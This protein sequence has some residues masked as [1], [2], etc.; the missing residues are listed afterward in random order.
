M[1][2]F[3]IDGIAL[4]VP[5]AQLTDALRKAMGA[6]LYEHVEARAVAQ[7]VRPG[8]RVL[9]LGAGAGFIAAQIARRAGAAGLLSVEANPAMI[10]VIKGNLA[11]N[12]A[13]AVSL[14]HGA[15]VPDG[16][17]GDEIGLH[18]PAGFWAASLAAP[19]LKSRRTVQ[20][21]ALR[22]GQ[23]LERHRPDVVVMDIEGAEEFLFEQ[24]WPGYLRVLVL[25][26]HPRRY[27]ASTVQRIFDCMSA[28]GLCY[29][30][31]GSRGAV[32]VFSRVT[33]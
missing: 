31:D 21:P 5:D 8:D 19:A 17:E 23:L 26:L 29:V 12:G 4:E 14:L 18:V 20:V 30:A 6:G 1:A 24:P 16:Y 32:V 33:E 22:L 27:P 10:P 13:Q 15:V 9:E 28:S 3:Q 11:R 7:H 25:E 2:E